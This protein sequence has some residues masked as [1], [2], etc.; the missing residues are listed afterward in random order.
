MTTLHTTATLAMRA[1]SVDG[2]ATPGFLGVEVLPLLPQII[3]VLVVGTVLGLFV[4]IGP[5]RLREFRGTA[6]QRLRAVLPYLVL[7]GVV[8]VVNSMLRDIGPGLSWIIGWQIT[9]WIFTIEGGFVAWLQSY[10][11]PVANV[12]FSYIYVYGYIFLMV[13]PVIAY[14]V[15]ADDRPI[16][17]TAL[18]Y[19]INYGIGVVC[20]VLFIAYGPRN[21]M[22]DTV[23]QILYLNWPES[24]LLT[25]QINANVNVFPSLHTS[26]SVSVVALAYRTRKEYPRWVPVATVLAVSV[27]IATMYLG[28]HWATDVF[29]GVLLGLFS[30]GAAAWLTSP[31]RRDSRIWRVGQRLRTPIDRLVD[32]L[33]EW[34]EKRRGT[35]S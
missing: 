14:L 35:K 3:A 4:I 15:L 34:L 33:L 29:F 13:F 10:S 18:A 24:N 17:E 30:V 6:A 26:L 11:H 1:M 25:S 2:A 27:M 23:D 8:L 22:P 32:T 20:Y 19:T 28:I 5:D 31:K 12:Y 9:D 21:V 7:L 16:K